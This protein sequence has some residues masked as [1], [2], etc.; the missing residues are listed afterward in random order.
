MH[1]QQRHAL[2]PSTQVLG[3]DVRRRG[4]DA[5]DITVLLEFC[6]GGHLLT[7]VNALQARGK[8]G[9]EGTGDNAAASTFW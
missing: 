8:G 4:P 6:P 7:R 9:G 1:A 3:S 5:T 2:L